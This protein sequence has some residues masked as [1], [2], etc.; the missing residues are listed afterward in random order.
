MVFPAA[1]GHGALTVAMPGSADEDAAWSASPPSSYGTPP[2]PR[3]LKSALK[4][5]SSSNLRVA[6]E[7]SNG[8]SPSPDP[9]KKRVTIASNSRNQIHLFQRSPADAGERWEAE[10]EDESLS[11]YAGRASTDPGDGE[12]LVD[13]L[14]SE[15]AL[16]EVL[17]RASQP[18]AQGARDA[19]MWDALAYSGELGGAK[20]GG[21]GWGVGGW[22]RAQQPAKDAFERDDEYE[23]EYYE[24]E[25]EEEKEEEGRRRVSSAF[26][27]SPWA[28]ASAGA[29]LTLGWMASSSALILVN[30][31]LM[32]R[33]GFGFPLALTALG[34]GASGAAGWAMHHLG[35]ARVRDLPDS[36]VLVSALLPCALAFAATLFLGNAAYL[37]LSVAFLNMLKAATPAA[38]LASG[39][40][41][42]TARLTPAVAVGTLL[43][44]AGS[45]AATL[46]ESA[47]AHSADAPFSYGA[48]AMFAGSVVFEGLR[49]VLV[50][51]LLGG[52]KKGKRASHA[53]RAYS[54]VEVLAHLAPLTALLLAAGSAVFEG[55]ELVG[56]GWRVAGQ[57]WL[58]LL[59]GVAL[60][61]L[62]NV[63]C[64]GAIQASSSV[65]FKL[66][67]CLKN[68]GVVAAGVAMGDVVTPRELQGYALSLL[69][70]LVF[71]LG[72][73]PARGPPG[74]D[75]RV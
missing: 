44:A 25:E 47:H 66:A 62:T 30:H 1:L 20:A 26:P 48:L 72:R 65:A 14:G 52:G 7:F 73:L 58:L 69:G 39:L 49:V 11:R 53:G 4:Q 10:A 34:Q 16:M 28:S 36:R 5:P 24:E 3:A 32:V 59:A 60:A 6:E 29:A 67:G 40:A 50:E 9:L 61:F 54:P 45:V 37:G 46:Q 64:Y 38:T 74:K 17:R 41:L 23:E 57:H 71:L 19:G 12:F 2:P 56:I 13:S 75:K 43:V 35:W 15:E 51:R 31:R 18:A 21:S 22:R 42:G 8:A 33:A 55:P 27:A 70:F 63:L 68:V